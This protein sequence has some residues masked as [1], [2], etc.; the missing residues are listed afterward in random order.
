[1]R[2]VSII[3]SLFI[4]GFAIYIGA[5]TRPYFSGF[6]LSQSAHECSIY[7]EEYSDTPMSM[8]PRFFIQNPFM[9]L[10]REERLR[11]DRRIRYIANQEP[12]FTPQCIWEIVPVPEHALNVVRNRLADRIFY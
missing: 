1:M 2:I 4:V 8:M 3:L 6:L 5:T 12:R 9:N 10:P 7:S 11:R